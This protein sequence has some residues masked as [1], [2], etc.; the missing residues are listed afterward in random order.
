MY[1]YMIKSTENN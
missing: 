1:G